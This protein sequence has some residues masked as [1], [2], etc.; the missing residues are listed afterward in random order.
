[1]INYSV[2]GDGIAV[3]EWDQ[4]GRPQN[5]MNGPSLE[6]FFAAMDGALADDA[7]RG[8]LV[9][10]AKRDFVAGG[11]LQWLQRIGSAAEVFE[12]AS[13][14]HAATRRYERGPKPVA[15]AL[16]GSALGGGLELALTCHYRVAADNPG[17]RF[18]LPEATLGLL[19]GG[20]GTQRLARLIGYAAAV[21]LGLGAGAVDAALNGYVARHYRSRHMNWLHACWGIGAT[22]GPFVIGWALGSGQGWRGGA[23]HR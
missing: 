20:G 9:T 11:D 5:V 10:S 19:P 14:Y 17:A 22:S 12:W 4:P 16:P 6:A 23:P 18:G 21:P 8:I 2:D 1:M 13:G 7:V 3:V 15:C